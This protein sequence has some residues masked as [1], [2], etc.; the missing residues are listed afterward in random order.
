MK[1]SHWVYECDDITLITLLQADENI[2]LSRVETLDDDPNKRAKNAH[3]VWHL[4]IRNYTEEELEIVV[5]HFRAFGG[6]CGSYD[7]KF[8]FR[9]P[10]CGVGWIT[11][12]PCGDDCS[13]A[14]IGRFPDYHFFD[15]VKRDVIAQKRQ[16]QKELAEERGEGPLYE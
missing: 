7:R 9:C 1:A 2:V 10:E 3:C 16:A 13:R 8:S 11:D 15:A 4:L 5:N 14:F 12:G 6:K